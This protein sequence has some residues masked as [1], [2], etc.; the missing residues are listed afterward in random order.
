MKKSLNSRQG[1]I[2]NNSLKQ[3]WHHLDDA[4]KDLKAYVNSE[5]DLDSED[6]IRLHKLI[7]T[8][9]EARWKADKAMFSIYP[10]TI[11]ETESK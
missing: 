5:V 9:S 10:Y 8:I 11:E 3:A 2:I 1:Q 6:F 7:D 4:Y